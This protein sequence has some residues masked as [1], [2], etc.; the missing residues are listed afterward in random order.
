[1]FETEAR[2]F[3]KHRAALRAANRPEAE[4]NAL[5]RTELKREDALFSPDPN[6]HKVGAFEGANY[7]ATGYYRSEMQCIMF[8]RTDQFCSVCRAAIGNIIDLYAGTI[9]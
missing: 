2:D 8:N 7:E 4:M 9:K 5:F 6:R 1:V 3:Q